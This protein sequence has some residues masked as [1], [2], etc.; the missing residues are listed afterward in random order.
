LI[1]IHKG[2]VMRVGL[3]AAILAGVIGGGY[4]HHQLVDAPAEAT[5]AALP[6]EVPAASGPL[7]SVTEAVRG[8][9]EQSFSTYGNLAAF[10]HVDIA[11]QIDGQVERIPVED[12]ATVSKGQVIL[13]IDAAVAD[14]E[15]KAASAR[16]DAAKADLQRVQALLQ[17]GISTPLALEDAQ[18]KLALAQTD[19]TLKEQHRRRYTILAPF[20]G[21]I[22][23]V[24]LTEG[25][26]IAT[27]KP[28]TRI[29]EQDRLRVEFQIPERLWPRVRTGQ[30]FTIQAD[31][32][33]DL[34][35]GGAV[36]YV[37]P[38]ANPSSR[39]LI[40]TGVIENKDHRFAAGLFVH[41][42]LDLGARDNVVLVP[43]D[44][45]VERLSGSYVFVV[46]K[47]KSFER[48]VKLGE[49]R[50][51]RVEVV[52]GVEEGQ[53]VIVSGQKTIRDN[54]TVTVAQ[55]ADEG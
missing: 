18:V 24:A 53:L 8:S 22:G 7:V 52:S 48:Q 34:T 20:A 44:A 27:G 54:M 26:L 43:E 51:G 16:F 39:S 31:G 21:R 9:L 17:R 29:T 19:M 6:K 32:N 3:G 25:A 50:D 47:D 45:V 13:T 23:Q 15:L 49:R 1:A 5:Q 10:R 30:H 35:V 46:E 11:A 42:R 36:S 4:L 41:I 55:A 28:I 40:V 33:P 37:S 2:T 38:D 12:G 14:A